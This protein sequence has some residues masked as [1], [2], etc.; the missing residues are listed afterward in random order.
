[1]KRMMLLTLGSLALVTAA[2]SASAQVAGS[3]AVGV[4]VEEMKDIVAGWSAEKQMLGEAVYNERNEMVG[5]IDDLIVAPNM[6]VSYTIVGAG[7]F[8]GLGKHDVAI[9]ITQL[10]YQNGK[11]ILP[12]AT[13]DMVKELPKFEYAKSR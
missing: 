9:P 7:G 11:F 12:G 2:G 13:R 4:T 3:T 5:T 8:V 6:T 1:M 10:Q